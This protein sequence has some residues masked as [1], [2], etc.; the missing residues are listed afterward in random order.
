MLQGITVDSVAQPHHESDIVVWCNL[1]AGARNPVGT[2]VTYMGNVN[3]SEH[4]LN[5]NQRCT[6]DDHGGVRC[7]TLLDPVISCTGEVL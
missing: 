2:T 7:H 3:F 1:T 4:E 6:V 5:H